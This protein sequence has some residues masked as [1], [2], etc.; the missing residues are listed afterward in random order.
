MQIVDL[1]SLLAEGHDV[2]TAAP[3][4]A[5]ARMDCVQTIRYSCEENGNE[6]LRH[7][8]RLGVGIR[9]Y[10][11]G[12]WG[13]A[14]SEGIVDW[15][16]TLGRAE[17][18]AKAIPA[19]RALPL[20]EV[21]P[22]SDVKKTATT[23]PSLDTDRLREVVH[24]ARERLPRA[25]SFRMRALSESGM[26]GIVN[27]EGTLA[28]RPLVRISLALTV[29]TRSRNDRVLPVALA[30]ASSTPCDPV[31][32]LVAQLDTAENLI[33]RVSPATAVA[34]TECPV[35]LGPGCTAYLIHE[36][37]GHLCEAD[38]IPPGQSNRVPLGTIVG[39][40]D[41]EVWD[42][43]DEPS[44]SGSL[45]F[46]DEGVPCQAVCLISEG[47]WNALLHSRKT[48]G[49]FGLKPTGNARA[50]S[51]RF[52]PLC[53]MR[54]T[55]LRP[56]PHHPGDIISSVSD[57]L[58][59]DLPYGGHIRGSTFHLSAM[60][61]R[62]IRKGT[63]AESFAGGVLVGKP[64]AIL[65]QIDAIGNDVRLVDGLGTCSREAQKDLP[66]SMVAPTILL[67]KAS[68]FPY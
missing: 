13:F 5:D 4:F 60:D 35:V 40:R 31:P 55:E 42:R 63:L 1:V 57:G 2:L 18:I 11:D 53:R 8:R 44:A 29:L 20:A 21:S 62:R 46:D 36:A 38:R 65:Q 30:S 51:F 24:E 45:P 39:P 43:G 59:L 9:V 25:K 34:P 61:V 32:D 66:V 54:L 41:L 28:T 48:A 52:P 27:S 33:N 10:A 6:Q 47:R 3:H 68:V 50:T 17:E 49:I 14:A 12:R 22:F 26:R 23:L 67:R 56:G 16:E 64:L 37:F 58:Y 7:R 19:Q 15:T